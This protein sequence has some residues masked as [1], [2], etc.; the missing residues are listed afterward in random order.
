M[1]CSLIFDAVPKMGFGRSK[2]HPEICVLCE[3][4]YS[5][6]TMADKV[7]INGDVVGRDVVKNGDKP[8]SKEE[9]KDDKGGRSG[10]VNINGGTVRI[11]GRVVSGD[12]VDKK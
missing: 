1:K 7:I 3:L 6:E 10:G 5:E 12:L 8:Q 11:G 9:K 4:F 2:K